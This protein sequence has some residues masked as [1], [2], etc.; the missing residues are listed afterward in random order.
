MSDMPL[1]DSKDISIFTKHE[2]QVNKKCVLSRNGF[3]PYER[4]NYCEL[5]VDRCTGMQLNLFT[6]LIGFSVLMFL[7]IQDPFLVRLNIVSIVA[8][9][10]IL[11]YQVTVNTDSLARAD[12]MNTKL[13]DKLHTH[14]NNLEEEIKVRTKELQHLAVHDTITGLFNRYEFEKRLSNLI[15]YSSLGSEQSIMCYLDLDQF[16]IV[17]D[18]SGHVAGDELLKRVAYILEQSV[19]T[20]DVVARLGGD[21]F[22]ILF[23]GNSLKEAQVK[24]EYM[25]KAVKE[26]R[27][28][29]DEKIFVVGASIGLVPIT[30]ECCSLVDIIAAADEACYQA[31]EQGRNGVYIASNNDKQLEKRR[32]E[33]QWLSKLSEALDRDRFVLYVQPI[34]SI[35]KEEEFKHYEVL[36]RLKDAQNKIILPMAFIPS[37]ERYG[38]M[39][40]IDRWVIENVFLKFS[41]LLKST[42]IK[43]RFSINLSGITLNDK[44]LV[45]YIEKLFDLYPI[46]YHSICFEVT[47]TAAVANMGVALN[48]INRMK[49]LGCKVSLDD[50]GSGLS[51]FAYLQNMP[52]NYL[53]IDGAFVVDIHTNKINRA[54]VKSI[55]E[56]GHIMGMKTICEYVENE[57]IVEILKEM[58]VDYAQGFHYAKPKP[59]DILFT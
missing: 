46:P 2:G 44:T 6:F 55:N 49:E 31:K 33:M 29:W 34:V 3:K 5:A 36:I 37:A 7:F 8:M 16:K 19:D 35:S 9:F 18:T 48:F 30:R 27:F 47:E 51:S 45:D 10:F 59:I 32:G 1:R 11:G 14:S 57:E 25:L 38:L 12:Y 4:C 58:G 26:Y 40:R 56:V 53:K 52:V 28:L 54:M 24:C 43:Y 50:F 39:N 13:N 21:E 41:E 42:D 23:I 20:K 22:G 17:N 15:K